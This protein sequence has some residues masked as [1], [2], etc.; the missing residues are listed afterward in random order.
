VGVRRAFETLPEPLTDTLYAWDGQA[1]VAWGR[2]GPS[3]P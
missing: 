2:A 3:R 1:W